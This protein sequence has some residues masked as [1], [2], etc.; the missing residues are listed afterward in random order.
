M[1]TGVSIVPRAVT[2]RPTRASELSSV[3]SS[4]NTGSVKG[5]EFGVESEN[6]RIKRVEERYQSGETG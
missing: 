5:D 3:F 1:K 6:R 2:S 4:L